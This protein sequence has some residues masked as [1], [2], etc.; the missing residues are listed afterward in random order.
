MQTIKISSLEFIN[1]ANNQFQYTFYF[2]M[3]VI[4]SKISPMFLI[5]P[6]NPSK[7]R[8][9]LYV[10]ETDLSNVNDLSCS[11]SSQQE[12]CKPVS[13]PFATRGN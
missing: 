1:E 4:F 12:C 8:K 7:Q 2:F 9:Q 3:T 10:V 6:Q 13:L 11:E 5:T